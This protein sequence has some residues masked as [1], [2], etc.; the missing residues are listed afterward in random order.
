M[1]CWK[2]GRISLSLSPNA[3]SQQTTHSFGHP[4]SSPGHICVFVSEDVEK[5]RP[6]RAKRVKTQCE[7]SM[8]RH[9]SSTRLAIRGQV[10]HFGEVM[11][12][13]NCE[14]N[15]ISAF[16]VCE[17]CQKMLVPDNC[18]VGKLSSRKTAEVKRLPATTLKTTFTACVFNPGPRAS[19]R[20]VINE[21]RKVWV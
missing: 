19:H 15:V 20:T 1:Q 13:T 12:V 18:K 8:F 2:W 14:N 7:F 11:F 4:K 17:Q 5:R 9:K 3:H 16:D 21:S 10:G 6:K